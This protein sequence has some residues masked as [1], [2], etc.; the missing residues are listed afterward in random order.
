MRKILLLT[1]IY[2]IIVLPG[3]FAQS[4]PLQ[5]QKKSTRFQ[6][7]NSLVLLNGSQTVS[8]ALQSVN[9]IE[10][11]SFFIGAG[12][13]IDFYRIRSVP[14]F[15]DIR[16]TIGK[17]KRKFFGYTDLGYHLP[18]ASGV[19]PGD[20]WASERDFAGGIYADFGLGYLV[21]IGKNDALILSAGY[22]LKHM[23]ETVIYDQIC[24]DPWPGISCG[25]SIN[26]YEYRF[27]RLSLKVGWRF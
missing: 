26:S 3:V 4:Q 6:S 27:N 18:W 20:S 24:T 10:M 12:V 8:G 9:G 23:S 17:G 25:P 2:I 13:G 21:A 5:N 22:A 7:Y 15:I 14:L 1:G 11:G 16:H 19:N